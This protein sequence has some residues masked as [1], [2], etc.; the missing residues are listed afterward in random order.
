MCDKREGMSAGKG[1]KA[2]VCAPRLKKRR[3]RLLQTA[4]GQTASGEIITRKG[5]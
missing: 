3:R 5:R 4:E 1:W 2:K